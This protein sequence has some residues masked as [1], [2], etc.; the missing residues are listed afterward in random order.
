MD[1]ADEIYHQLEQRHLNLLKEH[2]SLAI[3]KQTLQGDE[4][5]PRSRLTNHGTGKVAQLEHTI[6][7]LRSSAEATSREKESFLSDS[8][9]VLLALSVLCS[10]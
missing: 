2:Q 3:D 10:H 6:E 7:E 9:R 8:R 5:R 4:R 1:S